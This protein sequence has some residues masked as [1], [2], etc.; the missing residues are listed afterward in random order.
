MDML[1]ISHI[2]KKFAEKQVLQDVDFTVPEHAVYGF[3]GQNGA[4]KTT[5][6]KLAL[7]LLPADQGEIFVNGQKVSFGENP[8]NRYIGYLPDVPEFYPYMTASEYLHFAVQLREWMTESVKTGQ[9]SFWDW[10][11][12]PR[13]NTASKD[14]PGV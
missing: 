14:F 5:T 6:M 4:G 7:G 13:K 11:A 3:V 1:K 10:W 12:C 9:K 2:S 8:A